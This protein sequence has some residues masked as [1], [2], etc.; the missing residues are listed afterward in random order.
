MDNFL[1]DMLAYSRLAAAE[2]APEFS[3][4]E[5]VSELLTLV[6]KEI[7][8]RRLP[9]SLFPVGNGFCPLAYL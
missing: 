8:D 4:E 7:K 3:L 5:A 6:E 1:L 2:M 9:S